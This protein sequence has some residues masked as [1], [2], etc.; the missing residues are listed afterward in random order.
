MFILHAYYLLAVSGNASIAHDLSLIQ[1]KIVTCK[2]LKNMNQREHII[3]T[4]QQVK[5]DL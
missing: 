2:R 4:I 5:H 1:M 3:Q